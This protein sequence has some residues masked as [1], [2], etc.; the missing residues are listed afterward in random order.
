V[1]R[2]VWVV[3]DNGAIQRLLEKAME[4]KEDAPIF[5]VKKIMERFNIAWKDD[6]AI[7]ASLDIVDAY[8]IRTP[9][10]LLTRQEL[11]GAILSAKEGSPNGASPLSQTIRLLD[12]SHAL[13]TE[14]WP[15]VDTPRDVVRWTFL[16]K[17][18]DDWR[19]DYISQNAMEDAPCG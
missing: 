9:W 18:K 17:K 14:K 2:P 10:G 1:T 19:I 12:G 7:D 13:C 11:R 15:S 3:G 6:T 16:L 5:P 4:R 8:P